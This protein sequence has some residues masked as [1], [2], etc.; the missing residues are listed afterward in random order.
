MLHRIT[1]DFVSRPGE[2]LYYC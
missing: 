1:R 2:H